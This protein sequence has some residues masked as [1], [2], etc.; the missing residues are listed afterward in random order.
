MNFLRV[1]L[2]ESPKKE[3]KLR[4]MIYDNELNH[5]KNI[6]FGATGYKDYIYYFHYTSRE[7]ALKKKENYIKR[8]TVNEDWTK[9]FSKGT[10]SRY[11]LWNKHSLKESWRDYLKRF[12]L[13]QY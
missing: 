3:N 6:D 13:I 1:K 9:P 11:I 4:L 2:V 12:N 8:H 10:L 5:L 7:N